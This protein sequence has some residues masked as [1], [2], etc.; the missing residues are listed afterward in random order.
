MD[1]YLQLL[2]EIGINIENTVEKIPEIIQQEDLQY[3]SQYDEFEWGYDATGSALS[4]PADSCTSFVLSYN[5]E[6]LNNRNKI[7]R[8]SRVSRFKNILLK[9]IGLS[10][11]VIPKCII[12]CIRIKIIDYNASNQKLWNTIR[13][14]LKNN[15]YNKYYNDIPEIIRLIKGIKP[16]N[17]SNVNIATIIKDFKKIERA[18]DQYSSKLDRKYFPNMRYMALKL[19]T[20]HGVQFPYH[21]PYT[22]TNRKKK[23]L[24]ILYSRLDNFTEFIDKGDKEREQ[25]YKLNNCTRFSK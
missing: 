19:S 21:V 23:Y 5:D 1:V 14:I 15:G 16:I 4:G 8:Y 17:N 20:K 7:H 24:D 9:I 13:L 3:E 2:N 10:S 18:F 11:R 12:E 25:I 22:R 6:V